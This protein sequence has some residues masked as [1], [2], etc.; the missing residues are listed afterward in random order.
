MALLT[1]NNI[2]TYFYLD[3]EELPAVDDVSFTLEENKTLAIIGESGSGKS[4]LVLSI[5]GLVDKPGKVLQG[6]ALYGNASSRDLLKMKE[7]D[8]QKIRGNE[9]A[10]IYQDP[11]S[12]LNPL[13][14]VGKQIEEALLIHKKGSKKEN[15]KKTLQ[16]MEDVGISDA[17]ERFMDL[18]SKFSGG[19]RQRI[20][21]AMAIAC[22]PK[23]LIADE[24]TTALD[25][26]IQAEIL[27][28]L[29]KLQKEQKMAM[30]LNTHDLG[31]VKDMAHDVCVMYCGKVMEKSSSNEIFMNPLN[32][33][34][35]GLMECM[36]GQGNP[37]EKLQA[38]EG[39]V[40]HPSDF[41]KGCRFSTRCPYAIDKCHSQLPELSEVSPNHFVRCFLVQEGIPLIKKA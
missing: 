8:M 23:I 35:I 4:V 19:M 41:P 33:Y 17:Q 27:D 1:V 24:P 26:T 3:G 12:T 25:V 34:T 10:M 9:I 7:R 37:K 28:L 14:P 5:M 21:I 6:E 32:P 20:M 16:L 18:P 29:K 15:R 38:I 31:V 39:Y 22:N 36:P 2:K 13:I 11:M 40:P 30:I